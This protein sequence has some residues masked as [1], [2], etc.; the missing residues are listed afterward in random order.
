MYLIYLLFLLGFLKKFKFFFK[1]VLTIENKSGILMKLSD[2][3]V[4]NKRES[5]KNSKNF[6][7]KL[8]KLKKS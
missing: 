1:K 3:A 7:K 5:S 4:K 6:E 8:D 2:E